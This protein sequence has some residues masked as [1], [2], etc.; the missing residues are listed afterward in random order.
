MGILYI[1]FL[2][3]NLVSLKA[4]V[5]YSSHKRIGNWWYLLS[6]SEVIIDLL[7]EE[8]SDALTPRE[9]QE[10]VI[11]TELGVECHGNR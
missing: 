3:T 7:N 9:D 2:V 1:D 10:D 11:Q 8:R 4:A 5:L 6:F